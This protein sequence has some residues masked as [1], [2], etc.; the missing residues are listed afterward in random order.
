VTNYEFTKSLGSVLSRPTILPVPAFV[1]K[2]LFGEMSS[3]L[4][5]SQRVIPQ[6]LIEQGYEFLYTD[7]N[8]V[9]SSIFN[10]KKATDT[11]KKVRV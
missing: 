3:I 11:T 6:R 1:L 2:I 5:G 10:K 8:D 7:L 4:L 9:F